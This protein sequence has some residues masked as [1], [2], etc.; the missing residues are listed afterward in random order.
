MTVIDRGSVED[1]LVNAPTENPRI[2]DF[3]RSIAERT[4]PDSIE[5]ITGDEDQRQALL[6]KAIDA[7]TIVKLTKPA[8]SYYAASDPDD[9]A[10]VEDR[11][12]ICSE[13][14]EDAGPLNNWMAPAQM[15]GIL[16]DVFAGSMRGRTMYVIPFVM[17]HVN[18]QQPMFGIEVTDSPY[19]VLSM[20]VMA[21]AGRE[22][23]EAIDRRVRTTSPGRA[24]RR[25]TSRTSRRSGR[26]G[27]TAPA[28]AATHCWARSAT[29]CAS[30][31]P[32]RTT[33]A[34]WPSTCSSSSSRTRRASRSSSPPRSPAPAARP[35]SR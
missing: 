10:R 19:V 14:Q 9:V 28:T 35:T 11:T 31:P 17:G 18:A 33:R 2:L 22:S 26:S 12:F 30:P 7:G 34:G 20:G 8:D 32:S 21:R 25:S 13:K 5:W 4:T 15:K 29:R 27:R 24:A 16:E 3:V 1:L 23:L 6:Q